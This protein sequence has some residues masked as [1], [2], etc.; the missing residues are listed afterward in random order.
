MYNNL[1][2]FKCGKSFS[3]RYNHAKF[4]S[5]LCRK[6]IHLERTGRKIINNQLTSGTKG[7]MSELLAGADLMRLG[8]NVFRAL[9][10][11]CYCDLIATKDNKT[12]H[13]EVRTGYLNFNGKLSFPN[14][15]SGEIDFFIIPET[16]T[17][18]VYYCNKDRE[19]ID[20]NKL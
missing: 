8:F 1:R 11:S 20:V 17:G 15:V 3:N 6:E 2:C 16:N 14:R 4:C 19:I 13:I 10:P 18:K 9:S 7:A 12:Y 5:A